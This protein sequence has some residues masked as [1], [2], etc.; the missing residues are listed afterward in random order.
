MP[1]LPIGKLYSCATASQ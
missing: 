1:Y